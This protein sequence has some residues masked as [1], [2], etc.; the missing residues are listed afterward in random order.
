MSS[1]YKLTREPTCRK[2]VAR[3]LVAKTKLSAAVVA[4]DQ[5]FALGRQ[6]QR[7]TPT[8]SRVNDPEEKQ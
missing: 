6:Q 7:V 5:H 3:V 8:G 2:V 1:G 4:R